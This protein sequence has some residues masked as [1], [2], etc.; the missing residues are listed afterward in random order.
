MLVVLLMNLP[1]LQ[2]SQDCFID[3]AIN[4]CRLQVVQNHYYSLAVTYSSIVLLCVISTFAA[5]GLDNR[6]VVV[7]N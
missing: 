5:V 3:C 1:M 4:I 7:R 2:R 6:I